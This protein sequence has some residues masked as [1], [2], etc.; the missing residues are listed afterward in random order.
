MDVVKDTGS[1]PIARPVRRLGKYELIARIAAGG[2]AEVY[3][4]RLRGPMNF[5]K[6]VVVKVIHPH[7]ASQEEFLRMLLD[8]ARLSALI[9]HPRVVDIYE[10]GCEEGVY[11]IAMEFIAGQPL[12]AVMGSGIAGRPLD[13]CSIAR[14]IADAADGLHAAHELKGA[15]GNT[16]GLVHRDVSPGN[17]MV[18]HDGGV[19]IVDFGIAKARGRLTI[20]GVQQ[21]KG[22]VG[23]VAPEQLSGGIVDRRTDVFG[24]GVVMWEALA[25]QRLF[26]SEDEK[27]SLRAILGSEPPTPSAIRPE[28]PV[29]LSAICLKALAPFPD[30]R[31][32]TA[33]EMRDAI[34]SFL[35]RVGYFREAGAI[36]NYME[37]VFGRQHESRQRTVRRL[38][39][40][41]ITGEM[42]I[43]VDV[44]FDDDDDDFPDL[45]IKHPQEAADP[46]S[47]LARGTPV[48]QADRHTGSE[49]ATV[50][51]EALTGPFAR[52]AT[53]P[54]STSTGPRR[55]T[56]DASRRPISRPE[57]KR[58]RRL[59]VALPLVGVIGVASAASFILW[60]G[61]SGT[62]GSERVETVPHVAATAPTA[63]P[64]AAPTPEAETS[65]DAPPAEALPSE[66]SPVE[67]TPSRQPRTQAAAPEK[68]KRSAAEL[69][70]EGADLFVQGKAS[71]AKDRFKQAIV[72][73][74]HFAPAFRGLGLVYAA[75]KRREKARK[76]FERYLELRPGANDAD[77]IRKRIEQLGE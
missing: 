13:P 24:L 30:Y 70:D 42:P 9:K 74:A 43:T 4:A 27:E 32:Q 64:T 65:P 37:H 16:L 62:P 5:Q 44:T 8:E 55:T 20:S 66:P 57:K 60:N 6:A 50:P 49:D 40:I 25:M 17:I 41:T 15:S 75:E 12:T 19:K 11:F 33:G 48:D 7:L 58:G 56:T 63:P 67:D 68:E 34:E 21:F 61:T 2:M 10:L 29:E 69:Y 18:L 53:R 52:P 72:A 59:L 22:K 46:S 31:F 45:E 77:A 3:L 54:S 1:G 47:D 76:S 26:R 35:I 23:Y 71:A 51:I 36:R 28:V 39:A 38:A 14:V 73:D